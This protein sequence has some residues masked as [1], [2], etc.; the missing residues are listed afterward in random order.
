MSVAYVVSKLKVIVPL[1]LKPA[2]VFL[3]I[4][5][6]ALTLLSML[7]TIV[8]YARRYGWKFA[9]GFVLLLALHEYGHVLAAKLKGLNVTSP[10]FIPFVGA[11]IFM[12]D[13]PENA[14]TEAFVAA[15]GPL[16]GS[17]A[18]LICYGLYLAGGG[19]LFLAL[20][21]LGFILNLFN[22]IPVHPLDGGRIVA[23]VSPA[24]WI[25]GIPVVGYLAWIMSDPILAV[26]MVLG[27]AQI[28]T[29]RGKSGYLAVPPKV[30]A[31][32][33]ATYAVLVAG[34]G[35]MALLSYQALT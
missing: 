31:A 26:I 6:I 24:I 34:L 20:A 1:L 21:Y 2:I 25:L 15:G 19:E 27:V 28:L 22:L 4:N 18:S 3:K 23:A 13:R 12:K 30:R 10:V 35:G 8:V 14:N 5:K 7:L 16:A 29:A 9:I 33:A 17:L 32:Y 11:L